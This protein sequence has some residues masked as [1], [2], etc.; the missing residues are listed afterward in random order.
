MLSQSGIS[1]AGFRPV[2]AGFN[3][4][5]PAISKLL[6]DA[7]NAVAHDSEIVR[8]CLARALALLR[9]D[10]TSDNAASNDARRQPVPAPTRS[11]LAPW[12]V[13]RVTAYFH[14]HLDQPIRVAD[15]AA[16]SRLSASYFSVAFRR[17]FGS[18]L[19]GFLSGLRV[20]RAQN[21]ML[22]T[23]QPLS[24]IALD[25]GF[26]DQAH[27]SRQFRRT[28]GRTPQSWRR[29]HIGQPSALSTGSIRL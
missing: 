15:L 17:S 19:R 24:R 14:Q 12:Q 10:A 4:L 28:V 22:S 6:D 18:S 2:P 27:L 21:L 29:E 26:C 3:S 5:A 9:D 25:C 1:P 16:I 20:E 8:S 11:G 7:N 23:T 13:G